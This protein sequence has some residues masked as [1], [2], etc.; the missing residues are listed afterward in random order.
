MVPSPSCLLHTQEIFVL[1][2]QQGKFLV[3][4]RG[5]AEKLKVEVAYLHAEEQHAMVSSQLQNVLW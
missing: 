2:R 1:P 3:P 4:P 5:E